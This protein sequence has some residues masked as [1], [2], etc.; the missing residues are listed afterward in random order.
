MI[1]ILVA[2]VALVLLTAFDADLWPKTVFHSRRANRNSR[3]LRRSSVSP[4]LLRALRRPSRRHAPLSGW[5]FARRNAS[6]S[7]RWWWE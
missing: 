1:L 4:L 2:V 7:T 6:S 5:A 3:P